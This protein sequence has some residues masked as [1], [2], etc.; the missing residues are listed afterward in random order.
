MQRSP[1]AWLQALAALQALLAARPDELQQHA[2][3][4]HALQVQ[5]GTL[6]ASA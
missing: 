4:R 3:A 6:L 2:G 1:R 5:L